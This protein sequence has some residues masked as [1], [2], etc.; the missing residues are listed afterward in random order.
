MEDVKTCHYNKDGCFSVKTS[1]S[2]ESPLSIWHKHWSVDVPPKIKSFSWCVL[3]DG[4][5]TRRNLQRRSM[6]KEVGMK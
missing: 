4:I 5:P 6:L 3:H 1:R 2:T